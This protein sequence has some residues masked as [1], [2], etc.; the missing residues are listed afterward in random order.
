MQSRL[1]CLHE[2]K[3]S[4]QCQTEQEGRDSRDR[5]FATRVL[6]DNHPYANINSYKTRA[7]VDQKRMRAV[8]MEV[9]L[10]PFF[11]LCAR[12]TARSFVSLGFSREHN[13]WLQDDIILVYCTEIQ[14]GL[15]PRRR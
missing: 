15:G 10:P 11:S 13:E 3:L 1:A 9:T 14:R 6:Q 5:R 2:K 12:A 7:N 8:H 4:T